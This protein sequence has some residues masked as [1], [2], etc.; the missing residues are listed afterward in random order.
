VEFARACPHDVIAATDLMH[1]LAPQEEHETARDRK[2]R[3]AAIAAALKEIGA[4]TSAEKVWM[5]TST[6]VW[7]LRNPGTWT[8]MMQ[9][10]ATKAKVIDEA[11]RVRADLV[12]AKWLAELA[13]ELWRNPQ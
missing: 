3:M 13:I 2:T 11:K 1:V 4:Q 5:D 6:R 12:K 9:V 7:F 10:A 8:P